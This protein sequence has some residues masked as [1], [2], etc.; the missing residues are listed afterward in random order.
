MPVTPRPGSAEEMLLITSIKID[1]M[2]EQ[3]LP[4]NEAE[5]E[6]KRAIALRREQGI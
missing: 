2:R 3:G 6:A 4:S 5:R 1:L